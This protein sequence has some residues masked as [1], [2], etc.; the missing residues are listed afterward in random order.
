MKEYRDFYFRKA[1]AE[2][3]PARSVYKLKELDAR[4]HLLR[5]GLKVLDLG[6]APGSWTLGAS[7]KVGQSGLV[8]ASDI[9]AI[10]MPL[11]ANVRFFI[12]DVFDPAPE[13]AAFL[14]EYG[15]FDFVM[16][17]MAPATTG[18]KFVDQARSLNLALEALNVA[19]R[20]L[21]GGGNFVVKIFMGPDVDDLLSGMRSRFQSVKIFKPKSSRAESKEIFYIGFGLK[22]QTRGTN[23]DGLARLDAKPPHLCMGEQMED[24]PTP[25]FKRL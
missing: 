15:P 5:T 20:H 18:S 23:Q 1:R 24:V 22:P 21:R 16:S 4:Y 17:D 8:A 12:S 14:S 13:F 25:F 6:A 10:S 3:Y 7:E 9:R 19:G 2:N 11:P